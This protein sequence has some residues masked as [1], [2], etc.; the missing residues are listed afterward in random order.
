MV[1]LILRAALQ[2]QYKDFRFDLITLPN[3]HLEEERNAP[4]A[5]VTL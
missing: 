2:K 1:F 4:V 3:K 5:A